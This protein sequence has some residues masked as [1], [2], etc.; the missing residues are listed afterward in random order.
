MARRVSAFA[1]WY[2][3]LWILIPKLSFAARLRTAYNIWPERR[4][5]SGLSIIRH[6]R[7][8]SC[9]RKNTTF[10]LD[11]K[12]VNIKLFIPQR[13]YLIN[14]KFTKCHATDDNEAIKGKKWT[15]IYV[16]CWINRPGSRT[17]DKFQRTSWQ[18]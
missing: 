5:N 6:L 8:K 13:F 12:K 10:A 16:K 18:E 4:E 3:G 9:H 15:S 1:C 17:L 7:L 14:K 2:F 11:K